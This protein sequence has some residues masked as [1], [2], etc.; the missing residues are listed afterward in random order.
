VEDAEV[1]AKAAVRAV[2]GVEQV[3][4]GSELN[5]QR[6]RGAHSR[7]ELSYDPERSGQI[8]Y[9]LAPYLLPGAEPQG[10]NHGSPWTY[11][12]HV[13]LLLFGSGVVAGT[14]TGRVGIADLAPTLSALLGISAPSGAQG[15][16]LREAVR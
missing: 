3:L 2:P 13:P 7:S 6:V 8:F 15:R 4:T 9:V 10:T 16:V 12:T 5:Q 1:V 14:Y 11:D